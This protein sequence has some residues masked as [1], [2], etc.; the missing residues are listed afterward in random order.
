[1]KEP[2]GELEHANLWVKSLDDTVR[3]L[4][5]ALPHWR[6]RGSGNSQDGRW[7]HVGTEDTYL[8]LNEGEGFRGEKGRLNHLGFVVADVDGI[9]Q[10]M[11]QAGYREGFRPEAH[12][13]R[14]RLYFLDSEGL[15][16]E[17]VE[18]LSEVPEERNQY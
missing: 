3:F 7:V 15:E 5:T 1:M 12:L 13:F 2:G 11:E 14:K 6:V 9:R 8:C 4:T 17:F 10:R 16:W 18:Y